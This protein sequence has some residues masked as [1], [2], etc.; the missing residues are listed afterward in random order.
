VSKPLRIL[1]VD[2]DR[3]LAHGATL[4]LHA[5]GFETMTAVDGRDG[6]EQ[7]LAQRP[8]AAILDVQMPE[9]NGLEMIHQLQCHAETRNMPVVM[10]SASLRDKQQ[11]LSAGA[12]YFLTKPCR[13]SDLL[14]AI[15]VV[16]R[17]L[18]E[19]PVE[20]HHVSTP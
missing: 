18:A 9:M 17:N 7:A 4:R 1:I 20:T 15:G 2:D 10:L 14:T 5:A 12:R 13:G 11:A 19:Q 16:V 8:D 3:E 6:L